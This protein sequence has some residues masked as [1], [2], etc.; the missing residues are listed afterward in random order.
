MDGADYLPRLPSLSL[1]EVIQ[2]YNPMTWSLSYIK[3]SSGKT[4]WQ[5]CF[6]LSSNLWRL[7][8]IP[9]SFLSPQDYEDFFESKE[10]NTVFAFLGLSS[11][12]SVKVRGWT[13]NI[14]Q[15]KT[16]AVHAIDHP[17]MRIRIFSFTECVWKM[18]IYFNVT[19]KVN[20]RCFADEECNTWGVYLIFMLELGPF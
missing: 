7:C 5:G 14:H 3:Q 19:L 6:K 16:K 12:P 9:L 18:F 15:D 4:I 17:L 11:K 2:H 10:S 13:H 1:A 8:N 20:I